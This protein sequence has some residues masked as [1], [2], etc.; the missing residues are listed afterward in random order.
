MLSKEMFLS[1]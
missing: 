1:S